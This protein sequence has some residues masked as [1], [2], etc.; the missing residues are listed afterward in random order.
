MRQIRFYYQSPCTLRHRNKIK[1]FLMEKCAIN[2]IPAIDIKY[3]FVS[4]E[5]LLDINRK[6]LAHDFYTDIITF[7]LSDQPRML[8]AEIYIS[9]DRVRENAKLYNVKFHH[10]LL[11][12]IFHGMLH[13]FGFDDSTPAQ[14]STMSDMENQWLLEYQNMPT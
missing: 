10:E 5:F 8:T 7:D 9:V 1:S 3:I 13:L 6:H 11:R 2:H 4:D 12:V 14:R